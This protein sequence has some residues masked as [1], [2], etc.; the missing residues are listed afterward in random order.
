ME[1]GW[2]WEYE[3]HGNE[4]GM[5]TE[6]RTEMGMEWDEVVMV[7][8]TGTLGAGT[9]G[10]CIPQRSW[11][12]PHLP[13]PCPAVQLEELAAMHYEG[14]QKQ[15]QLVVLGTGG[16][17]RVELVRTMPILRS[18]HG[19]IPVPILMPSARCGATSS[20]LH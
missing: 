2:G 16:F 6:T 12:S 18:P 11:G 10:Q 1:M 4:M 13:Q 14:G 20:F 3:W 8:G 7:M 17:G 5:E 19:A 9:T 15:G